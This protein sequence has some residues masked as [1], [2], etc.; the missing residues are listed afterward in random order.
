ML[1]G[2]NKHCAKGGKKFCR[3]M[4]K[5]SDR[6]FKMAIHVENKLTAALGNG[7]APHW[8]YRASS[9]DSRQAQTRDDKK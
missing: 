6:A 9:W 7:F 3:N 2:G 4:P 8:A 5:L 1:W